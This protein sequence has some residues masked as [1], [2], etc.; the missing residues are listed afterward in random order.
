MPER[1]DAEPVWEERPP[2]RR[3]PSRPS[4]LP[5]LL[6]AVVTSALVT[7]A[8]NGIVKQGRTVQERRRAHEVT[9]DAARKR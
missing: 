3:P 1:Y 4:I 8:L 9:A 7:L 2:A 6:A 5:A